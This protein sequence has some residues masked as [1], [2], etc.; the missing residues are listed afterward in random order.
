[1]QLLI[2]HEPFFF[3]MRS[4]IL[5]EAFPFAARF[6]LFS[7]SV[8]LLARGLSCGEKF[9]SFIEHGVLVFKIIDLCFCSQSGNNEK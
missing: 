2:F 3:A 9:K 6:S 1:M 5:P 4:F 8:F 7:A